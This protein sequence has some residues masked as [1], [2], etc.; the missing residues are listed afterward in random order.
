MEHVNEKFKNPV[1][2]TTFCILKDN[3]NVVFCLITFTI[4]NTVHDG[5][6]NTFSSSAVVN[7]VYKM[8]ISNY[9]Q[10]EICCGYILV[11]NTESWPCY[12]ESNLVSG[13]FN[14]Y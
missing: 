4:W 12:V 14:T 1:K 11:F 9:T 8:N 13:L 5:F 10:A 2:W 6:K 7:V 3:N